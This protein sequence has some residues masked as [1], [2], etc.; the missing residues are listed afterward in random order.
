MFLFLFGMTSSIGEPKL[1]KPKPKLQ[2]NL[3]K[4]KLSALKKSALAGQPKTAKQ[5]LAKNTNLKK[6]RRK[7]IDNKTTGWKVPYI[8]RGSLLGKMKLKKGDVIQS[9]DDQ[10]VHSKKQVYQT[11][12]SFSKK[13]KKTSLFITR[14]KKNFLVLYKIE[15]FKAKKK[16]TIA[17]VKRVK[18]KS[19]SI[20][21]KSKTRN[22]RR[23]LASV[24]NQKT[25]NPNRSKS[26]F[27]KK[28]ALQKEKSTDK[29]KTV[30][31]NQ[32]PD[33]TK[34]NIVPE[35]YR[36]HLQVAYVAALNSFVYKK[37]NFDSPQLYPLPVGKKILIS[38]KIFRPHH[39][40][41]SF[42]KVFLFKEKKIVGYISE[43]EVVPEFL[44]QNG[45]HTVNPA[46]KLAKKQ[47][48]KDKVLDINL[49]D[50]E[51]NKK[52]MKKQQL[53]PK[54]ANNKKRY[55]G[56]SLGFLGDTFSTLDQRDV[57]LGL[58]LSGYN[59]LI[60]YLNMD[61]NLM[62]TPYDFKFFH[63]DILATYPLLRSPSYHLFAAGGFN[64][65]I[66]KRNEDPVDYGFSGALSLVIPLSQKFLFR[67]DAKITYGLRTR[68]F[69]YG[70][71]G[72]LQMAF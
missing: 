39:N 46:Y 43:A 35:K 18:K 14:N 60:S 15:P 58:K 21:K 63:F 17:N 32:P 44:K 11:L 1:S 59:L 65:T 28:T 49:I 27:S 6:A 69:L 5:S 71:L 24:P 12:L 19:V 72:S 26:Q 29:Q 45:T 37:P 41:G 2:K 34:Q 40:F 70:L 66:N 67:T 7:L 22:R 64:S 33:K 31:Q 38:K 62:T 13:Q 56:L 57:Y 54:P 55:I 61:L 16:F 53:P 3:S 30:I 52:Q 10:P 23:S 48:A 47:M 68:S 9:I 8:K 36:P 25:V 20:K 4:R 51:R 50:K 42:Y